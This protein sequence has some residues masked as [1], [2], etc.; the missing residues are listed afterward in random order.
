MHS[1]QPPH[2]LASHARPPAALVLV[3]EGGVLKVLHQRRPTLDA[4]VADTAHLLAVE[5]LPLAIVEA[6]HERDDVDGLRGG[7]ECGEDC[8]SN[9]GA[10]AQGGSI[11]AEATAHGEVEGPKLGRKER[12][13]S[14]KE[15]SSLRAHHAVQSKL[16]TEKPQCLQV[17]AAG[18]TVGQRKSRTA[19][20]VLH[21]CRLP[22]SPRASVW[23][24]SLHKCAHSGSSLPLCQGACSEA[25]ATL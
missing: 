1:V 4:G 16:H 23:S 10:H 17:E 11:W 6:L 3:H 2:A 12:R 20:Q 13:D 14:L 9:K 8:C 19:M 18:K 5:A 7:S 25:H 24:N 21:L 22:A 15:G